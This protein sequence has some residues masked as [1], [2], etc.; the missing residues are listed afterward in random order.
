MPA[1]DTINPHQNYF[2]SL[3]MRIY[4]DLH[5]INDKIP[6][7]NSINVIHINIQSCNEHLDELLAYFNAIKPK[8]HV[9]VLSETWL[10]F[11]E[12][13]LD[14]EGYKAIHSIR[15]LKKAEVLQFFP[16]SIFLLSQFP[17]NNNQQKRSSQFALKLR[18]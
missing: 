3:N 12:D 10:N 1:L 16:T 4:E 15:K 14:I 6:N 18:L 2:H 17:P 13:W 7:T 5:S 8:F 9:I 11:E